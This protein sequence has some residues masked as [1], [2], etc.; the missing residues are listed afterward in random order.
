MLFM[1]TYT[2]KPYLTKE[3]TKTL[4][5]VFAT[6]GP[7]PGTTAHYVAADGSATSTVT[8]AWRNWPPLRLPATLRSPSRSA[9]TMS[10]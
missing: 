4:M 6:E 3:E 1:T 5:Q 2:I 7:G 10:W 8:S 9:D